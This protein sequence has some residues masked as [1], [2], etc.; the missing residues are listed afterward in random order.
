MLWIKAD[1]FSYQSVYI[2]SK[3]CT[4]DL[5][6][7]RTI[8]I[9]TK[10]LNP[11][12]GNKQIKLDYVKKWKGSE[13]YNISLIHFGSYIQLLGNVG[14]VFFYVRICV[15]CVHFNGYT[16]VTI[17]L[18]MHFIALSIYRLARVEVVTVLNWVAGRKS[19]KRIKYFWIVEVNLK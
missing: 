8:S 19:E 16:M 11:T 18:Y 13:K 2:V 7:W 14:T 9:N 5:V 15:F 4:F 12:I 6:C 1:C 17:R 3:N 10:A